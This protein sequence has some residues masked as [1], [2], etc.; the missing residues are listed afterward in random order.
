MVLVGLMAAMTGVL[1]F[2]VVEVATPYIGGTAVSG[3][4]PL[5]T[6]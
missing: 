4:L 1:L 6:G 5:P 2:V 3:I